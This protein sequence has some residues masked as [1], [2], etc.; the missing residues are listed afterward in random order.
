ML[1]PHECGQAEQK[2]IFLS[3]NLTKLYFPHNSTHWL[4]LILNHLGNHVRA[5]TH[6]LTLFIT[7]ENSFNLAKHRAEHIKIYAKRR[8][9]KSVSKSPGK[10]EHRAQC[11]RRK[12]CAAS[13]EYAKAPAGDTKNSC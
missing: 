2:I 10:R 11:T 8:E 6:S 3:I 9:K 1:H 12:R 13:K 5:L 7:Q 4:Q